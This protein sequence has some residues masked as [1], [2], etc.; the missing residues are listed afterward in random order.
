MSED[1]DCSLWSSR[2][3]ENKVENRVSCLRRR[4]SS[5]STSTWFGL[6]KGIRTI[7]PAFPGT[8]TSLDVFLVLVFAWVLRNIC[9]SSTCRCQSRPRVAPALF[10]ASTSDHG[11]ELERSSSIPGRDKYALPNIF[12]NSVGLTEL[13]NTSVSTLENKLRKKPTLVVT[14]FDHRETH[15]VPARPSLVIL[16]RNLSAMC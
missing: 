10:V 12:E 6:D 3:N 13:L 2:S 1:R 11:Q 14:I 4:A 8:F 7:Q 15:R 9:T 5:S 16:S